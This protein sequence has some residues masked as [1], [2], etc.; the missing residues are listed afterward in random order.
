MLCPHEVGRLPRQP[1]CRQISAWIFR[2]VILGAV[3]GATESVQADVVIWR[4]PQFALPNR[5]YTATYPVDQL[6]LLAV[7]ATEEARPKPAW[8]FRSMPPMPVDGLSRAEVAYAAAVYLE[9]AGSPRCVDLYYLAVWNCWDHVPPDPRTAPKSSQRAWNLSHSAVARL[10]L[11]A[12]RHKRFDPVHGIQVGTPMGQ[13]VISVARHGLSWSPEHFG[14]F[15]LVGEYAAPPLQT[16]YAMPGMGVPVVVIHERESQTGFLAHDLPFGATVLLRPHQDLPQTELES[17]A[18]VSPIIGAASLEFY[19]PRTQTHVA[20]PIGPVPMARDMSASLAWA[21][22]QSHHLLDEPELNRVHGNRPPRARLSLTEPHRHG[23]I[24]VVFVHGLFSNRYAWVNV[25]NEL[26]VDPE[27]SKHFEYWVFEY[28]T[29]RNFLETAAML[30]RKLYEVTTELDPNGYDPGLSRIVLIGHSMG[31]LI[32]KLQVTSS[33]S[34]LWRVASRAPVQ[35]L[36]MDEAMRQK[37]EEA[38]FFE[39]VSLVRRVVFVGTPH[40]GSPYAGKLASLWINATTHQRDE[41][42]AYHALIQENPNR[43]TDAFR[44]GLPN[45]VDM[46]APRQPLLKSIERLPISPHVALHSIVGTAHGIPGQGAADGVVP[47]LSARHSKV[48]T[49]CYVDALHTELLLHR[50]AVAEIKRIL[51]MHLEPTGN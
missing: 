31:G 2:M 47:V 38:F 3:L 25:A 49:E 20:A 48:V 37:L 10:L 41:R 36:Q 40:R 9:E 24:P 34:E 42:R 45:S 23:R 43:F 19:D 21:L 7:G 32:G 6:A 26:Q 11:Q 44:H 5:Q 50:Q 4:R 18:L 22:K 51:R 14:R 35:T 29:S 8:W 46:L 30:R 13:V 1:R 39:P 17:E 12:N 15:E 27:I 16:R 33:G 28:D